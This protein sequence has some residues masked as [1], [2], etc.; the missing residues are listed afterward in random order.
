[1]EAHARNRQPSVTVLVVALW[2]SGAVLAI[3]LG[4]AAA[5]SIPAVAGLVGLLAASAVAAAAFTATRWALI[6]LLFLLYS[7]A[8]WVVGHLLGGPEVS[9]ALLLLVIAA[10]AWR[11]F[12]RSEELSVPGELAAL[13][14]LGLTYAASAAFAS[15]LDASLRNIRDFTG[16]AVTIVALVVLL[17]RPIWLRRAVWTVVLAGGALAII[18]L[19]QAGT[20]SY[21]NDFA[22]F[23]VARQEGPG[24]FRVGGPLDPNV[25]GQVLVATAV[26]AL[27]LALTARERASATVALTML[28]AC[29]A[30]TG[31]TGSR[32]AL[33][34]AAAALCLVLFLAP[35]PR[36][37]VA[38]AVALVFVVGLVFLPTGLKARVGL[39]TQTSSEQVQTVTKGSQNAIR[40]RKSENLAALR[41]FRDHPIVGVGPNNFPGHYLGYSQDI[42]LDPRLSARESH[43]LFLGALAETGIVGSCALGAVLWLALRGAWRGR[44]WLGGRDAVLAEGI[45]VALVSFLVA[46]LFLHAAYPRYLWIMVGFGF[47]AGQLARNEARDR[48]LGTRPAGSGAGRGAALIAAPAEPVAIERPAETPRSDTEEPRHGRGLVLTGAWLVAAASCVGI[49]LVVVGGGDRDA[50]VATSSA[51]PAVAVTPSEP[52]TPPAQTPSATPSAQPAGNPAARTARCDPII[53]SGMANSGKE[54]RLTSFD[55]GGNPIDCARAQSILLSALNGGGAAVGE[56]SCTTNPAGATIATC[57]SVDGRKLQAG[58]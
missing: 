42:G 19:I 8:G 49:I 9:Q 48:E 24:V 56:W 54:Y 30:V 33:I 38:A 44:R 58:G 37:L 53:G 18:S 25:F 43:S 46:G 17:D 20:G 3:V 55:P 52:A 22:G 12:P 41:M 28:A 13:L 47:V 29:L 27:Y 7:Y 6:V 2:S 51:P 31:L 39:P 21:E 36:G 34:A 50:T 57:T 14:V 16:Y 26:L 5:T 23:A 1:V 4:V 45:F 11:H 40:G 35:V 32:G 10:L 15:D